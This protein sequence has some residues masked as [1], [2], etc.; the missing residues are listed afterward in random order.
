M[1]SQFIQ[2]KAVLRYTD[3]NGDS[4][5]AG[6]IRFARS[7]TT[8]GL[9]AELE[10]GIL[11][12]KEYH[13][14]FGNSALF[15]TGPAFKIDFENVLAPK[16][17]FPNSKILSLD[18]YILVTNSSIDFFNWFRSISVYTLQEASALLNDLNGS[19][20]RL[21]PQNESSVEGLSEPEGVVTPSP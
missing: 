9:G 3:E 15:K 6:D 7:S 11:L 19:V 21:K 17:T 1:S 12:K 2:A 4:Q 14:L 5:E 16:F 20:V 18:T 13:N 10:I 8:T